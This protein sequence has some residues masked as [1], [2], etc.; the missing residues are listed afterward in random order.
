ML[1]EHVPLWMD[2]RSGESLSVF[3][4]RSSSSRRPTTNPLNTRKEYI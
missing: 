1:T 4:S 2:M 3:T